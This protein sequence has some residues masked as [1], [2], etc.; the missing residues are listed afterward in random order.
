MH[1]PSVDIRFPWK[2][3]LFTAL[4]LS[5]LVGLFYAPTISWTSGPLRVTGAAML[6]LPSLLN[7]SSS[8][9]AFALMAGFALG[10]TWET[11]DNH[12]YLITYWL[13]ACGLAVRGAAPSVWLAECSR[14]L[15]A[16][17]FALAVGWKVGA[18]QYLNGEFWFGTLLTDDRLRGLA[19]VF[20]GQS[21]RELES[22]RDAIHELALQGFE[23]VSLHMGDLPG[24]RRLSWVLSW[25]TVLVEA[26]V[27][28]SH[29]VPGDRAHRYRHI[30]LLSFMIGT[31][32]LMPVLGFASILAALGIA[33]ARQDDDATKAMYLLVLALIH[34]L[35]V[36]SRAL[37]G[38]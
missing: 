26:A 4:R 32:F 18:G 7:R 34:I 30:T 6:V 23:G 3:D 14:W 17:T 29:L 10:A 35:R 9:F 21:V 12:K 22:V 19:A 33:Q 5:V 8:W 28:V 16:A 38:G 27:T 20:T 13:F 15:V 2:A 24:L 25:L 11:S 37:V 31:Y 36:P 1:W